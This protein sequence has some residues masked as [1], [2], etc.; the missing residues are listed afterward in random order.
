MKTYKT[1][2]KRIVGNYRVYFTINK[3]VPLTPDGK[4]EGEYIIDLDAF[5][6]TL[7]EETVFRFN[8]ND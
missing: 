6:E 1:T 4:E 5:H 2:L 8:P 3:V 7:P